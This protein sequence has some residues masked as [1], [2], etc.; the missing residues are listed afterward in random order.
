MEAALQKGSHFSGQHEALACTGPGTP[1]DELLRKFWRLIRVGPGVAHQ[2]QY[3]VHHMVRHW[4]FARSFLAFQNLPAVDD[5]LDVRLVLSGGALDD[6]PLLVTFRIPNMDVEEKAV[7]LR[8]GKWVGALRWGSALRVQRTVD[9]GG[10]CVRW[11]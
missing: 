9:R 7:L 6:Q 2:I 4:D 5:W 3:E 1:A 10:A 11:R 8:L